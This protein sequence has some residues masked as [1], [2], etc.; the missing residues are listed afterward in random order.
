MLK[1]YIGP[2]GYGKSYRMSKD[3]EKL[4]IIDEDRKDII[5]LESELV[6]AD[7]MKDTVNSSFVMDY[8]IQ[9]LLENDEII[10]AKKEYEKAIDKAIID[11]QNIY[12]NIMENVLN[13]NS[14]ERTKDV[15][16]TTEKKEYKKIVKVDSTD[17]KKKMG[18][19]QK[20]QFMLELIKIST[21]KYIFLDEPEN[22]TH[23][24]LLHNTAKLIN[25][26]S[27][28]REVCVVTHSIDLL[29]ML[30]VD[31][32][33]LWIFNDSENYIPKK[34][35]FDE[36]IKLNDR[37]HL[38]NI[39]CKCRTYY[40][41]DKLIKNILELHKKEFMEALF[42]NKIY[43]VEGVNDELFLKKMLLNKGKL[44]EQYSI[45]QCYGKQQFIVFLKIYNSLDIETV[46]L[47]DEDKTS[48]DTNMA[49]N[50][51]IETFGKYIK[52]INNIENDIAYNGNKG[53][54]VKFIEYLD[55]FD[56]YDR[57]YD[58]IK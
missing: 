45:F 10:S 18:S 30:D 15:L 52:F 3:I 26:L 55:E 31:F 27:K 53:D 42:S 37:I 13:L 21:K 28:E 56:D 12:N 34:I 58:R 32:D 44:Y 1:I 11:N 29:N 23:P 49:I 25:D 48:D 8:L 40:N 19:G 36:S 51:Q 39:P 9:E 6:F 33:N 4:K 17:L 43:L 47:F 50:E 35:N 5:K 20:L 54:T 46:A 38:E 14:Q 57:Y 7:E 24:S 16:N 2:N 22:H 41:K